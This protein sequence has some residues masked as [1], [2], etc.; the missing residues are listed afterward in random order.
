VEVDSTSQSSISSRAE[1]SP[2]TS[3]AGGIWK[4]VGIGLGVAAVLVVLA[5]LEVMRLES[6]AEKPE[7]EI[8]AATPL[9]VVKDNVAAVV[10]PAKPVEATKPT[11]APVSPPQVAPVVAVQKPAVPVPAPVKSA[12]DQLKLQAIFYSSQHPS[13]LISG[14]LA[15]VDEEVKKCRVLDISPSSV[16]LQYLNQ[17]RTLVLR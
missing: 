12:L 14:E 11:P 9:P 5:R 6:S 15:S 3:M 13:A 10:T 8:I 7:V 1:R 16:T 4:W 2:E 17:R